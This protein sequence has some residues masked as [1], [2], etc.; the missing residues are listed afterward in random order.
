MQAHYQTI[1]F[2]MILHL[3]KK[4]YVSLLAL[5]TLYQI[6]I[7]ISDVH[8]A[9]TRENTIFFS[10]IRWFFLKSIE[11]HVY[12]LKMLD[13]VDIAFNPCMCSQTGQNFKDVAM[14]FL[15]FG[16]CFCRKPVAL[17]QSLESLSTILESFNFTFI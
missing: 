16:S 5:D 8:V 1:S 14:I 12:L 9:F 3:F 2:D 11:Q 6:N 7:K 4:T 15:Q 17:F 13:G 10:K